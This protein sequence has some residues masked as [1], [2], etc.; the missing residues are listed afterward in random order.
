VKPWN[1]KYDTSTAAQKN[2][3]SSKPLAS[4]FGGG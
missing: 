2:P 1:P 3:I 4:P